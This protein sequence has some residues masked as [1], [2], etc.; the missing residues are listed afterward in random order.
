[1]ERITHVEVR[2]PFVLSVEGVLAPRH[3]LPA[4][5]NGPSWREAQACGGDGGCDGG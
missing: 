3:R 1:M 4:A 5:S 2:R